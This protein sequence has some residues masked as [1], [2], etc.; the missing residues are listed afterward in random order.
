MTASLLCVS[1][2]DAGAASYPTG[3]PNTYVNT[4]VGVDDIV[5]VAKTQIGYQENSA[6]TKYGY[7]YNKTF[8]NQPW[9]AMFVSWCAEQAGVSNDIIKKYA[10]CS[11]EVAW[12]K[13]IG[14][15]YDSDYYGGDYTPK[16]GDVIF[17]RNSG[18]SSVSTH[19]GLVLGINGNYLNV[20]EGNATNGKVC[21]FTSNSSRMLNSS[22]VIGYGSPAYEGGSSS[23]GGIIEPTTYEQWQVDA[24]SLS[25]RQNPDTG[26]KRLTSISR[27]K[28][29]DVTE[30]ELT[31]D[32]LWG[33][34]EH[35]GHSGWC[36]LDYC[37]YLSGNIDGKYYQL[38]PAVSPKKASIYIAGTKKL[39]VTNGL[40]ANYTSNKASV[41]TVNKNGRITAVSEGK[42][43]IKCKTSTGTAKC[44]VTVKKPELSKST[45]ST[46]I[47]D[48][49]TLS[50]TGANED[51]T[52]TSSKSSVAKVSSK[53]R[54]T[55]VSKGTA[56]ITASV[57]GVNLECAV[58][59]TKTPK[60]YENFTTAKKSY[61]KNAYKGSNVTL[62][63]KGTRLK[64]TKVKYSSKYTWGKTKYD[65]KSG[66]VILNNCTYV[67]GSINGKRYKPKPYLACSSK[68]VYL[69]DKY[70]LTVKSAAGKVKYTSLNK[71]I[72]KVNSK[73]VVT[74][75]KKGT[76]YIT[77][78]NSGKTMKC[79]IRVVESKLS[80][81]E[82]AILKG[83]KST[84]SVIGG[85]GKITFKSSNSKVAK[86]NSKGTVT[87]VKYGTAVITAKRGKVKMTC[88]VSVFA[89]ALS[90]K[91]V[92]LSAG[93]SETLSV[94]R[95]S[96]SKIRW[97][98]SDESVATVSSRGK[99]TAV[100]PGEA[101]ITAEIDGA[102]LECK[103]TVE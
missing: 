26:S 45:A 38:P 86:V 5:A 23:S 77:A 7:W 40:G 98:S 80:K 83:N 21:E 63:P 54:V 94:T 2:A 19:T 44:V 1:F 48:S 9:C 37:S 103:V 82:L 66:W 35:G 3:Y 15:W 84:L 10:S 74:A 100:E 49:F 79:R 27:G 75:L 32:Y 46:C 34:T 88:K 25:L 85:S 11:A 31:D 56:N 47:G 59:V 65:G 29:I 68:S 30:F 58:T 71:S 57:S 91:A 72:A 8:V 41:A 4:G 33:Y 62:M 96:S 53:G 55:G 92:T 95:C 43:T 39:K 17:Y 76:V 87:A 24:D 52:W 13:S 78:K 22:Y 6:G 101:I 69:K 28:I 102:V 99:V 67:N 20:I 42:A 36:A 16:K 61:L 81:T 64:V 18:S 97:S 73:G 89:P 93:G 14:R 90:R 60:T 12:F 70:T 51:I 50:V